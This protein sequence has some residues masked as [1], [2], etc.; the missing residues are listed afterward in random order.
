M[1][2]EQWISVQGFEEKYEVSDFG[3]VRSLE[4]TEDCM[5]GIRHRAACMLVPNCHNGYARLRLC[6]DGVTTRY[7]VHRLVATHFIPNPNNY[8]QVNHRDGIKNNNH[9][10]NL[11]W[12]TGSMNVRHK[13]Y[14]LRKCLGEDHY[15]SAATLD[16]VLKI[17]E[18]ASFG[19]PCA[20]IAEDLGLGLSCVEHIRYRR[21]WKHVQ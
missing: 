17:R 13:F 12:C 1:D 14:T 11:E 19:T 21:S 3:R 2:N 16:Q 9:A 18:A 5:G 15:H 7:S 8:P 10:S 20:K 6:K 4:R